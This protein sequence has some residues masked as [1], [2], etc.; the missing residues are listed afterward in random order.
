M[1][2]ATAEIH[3]RPGAARRRTAP[4]RPLRV[5]L[6]AAITASGLLAAASAAAHPA[7]PDGLQAGVEFRLFFGLSDGSGRTVSQSEWEEFLAD[8]IIPR[9]RA[10]ST[11]VDGVGNWE[12]PDG[13]IQREPVKV[14]IG[15]IARTAEVAMQAVDEISDEF[16]QRFDQDPVFRTFGEVCFGL[17]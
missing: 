3:C 13:A 5:L 2:Q 9:F 7:C 10:G 16:E 6:V 1:S 12:D 8:T 17:S 4:L 14:V 15:L 11:V